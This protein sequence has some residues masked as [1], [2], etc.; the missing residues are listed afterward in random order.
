M[1]QKQSKSTNEKVDSNEK[2][3]TTKTDVSSKSS[4]VDTNEKFDT[5]KT[6]NS[7]K[8]SF[9]G[10]FV[11]LKSRKNEARALLRNCF[12]NNL[13]SFVPFEV[14]RNIVFEAD[15]SAIVRVSQTCWG[16]RELV[17]NLRELLLEYALKYR[18]ADKIPMAK[19]LI[20]RCANIGSS[21]A[22][23]HIAYAFSYS[24]GWGLKEDSNKA[25]AWF[26]KA[27]QRGNAGGIAC[28]ASYLLKGFE[29][30]RNVDLGKS[31]AEKA[32]SSNDFF[33]VGYCNYFEIGKSIDKQKA[34]E[35][36]KLS[37]EEGDEYGQYYFGFYSGVDIRFYWYSKS[38]EQGFAISQFY[39]AEMLRLGDGCEKNEDLAN[40]WQN[41][42][43]NQGY[44]EE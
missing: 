30:E 33:A 35:S 15:E 27:A 28:Y 25:L 6:N 34:L 14:W 16:F 18:R 29:A 22:M 24:G 17:D 4:S 31:L 9:D 19:N 43:F 21:R 42:A 44:Y 1:G 7:S 11:L 13:F 36:F 37:A 5:K 10:S 38:A 41:K 32:L 39:L 3:D 2:V 23:F 8:S 20:M 40:L 26:K 12:G